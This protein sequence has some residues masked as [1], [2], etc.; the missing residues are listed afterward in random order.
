MLFLQLLQGG[1]QTGALYALTAAGFALI[2]GATR[3]FHFAHGAAF[4]LAGYAFLMA[5]NAG[6]PWPLGA[7]AAI[8]VAVLFG[9][10]IEQLVYRPIGRHEGGFFTVFVAAF[11]VSIV[12]QNL[13][14][15]IAGR[16]FAVIDT[17]LSRATE[18]LPDLWIAPVFYVAI[19]VSALLFLALSLFLT[20]SHAGVALRALAQNPDLIR[21]YGLS[22]T[23]LSIL[24]FALG[25]A[26]AAPAAILTGMT[27]GLNEAMGHHVMLI[28][29]AATIVGGV[30]NL[31]GAALAG[32]LLGIAESVALAFVEPQWAEAVSFVVL[33]GFI[34]FRPSGLFGVA[35]A[36]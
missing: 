25:S 2:F 6:W 10:A 34:L 28:S 20:R 3:I 9:V 36:R 29:M 21:T 12:V 18:V 22:S 30:G 27:V 32:L 26:L 24:A 15:M 5:W 4:T 17:P 23:R 19:G 8:A 14:G 1:V 11:G 31:K 7:L 35:V 13:V 16:G 33:F